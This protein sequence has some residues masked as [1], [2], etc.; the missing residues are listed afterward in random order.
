MGL[1]E[2]DTILHP[3]IDE[4]VLFY[5]NNLNE[6]HELYTRYFDALLIKRCLH[7]SFFRDLKAFREQP[8]VISLLDKAAQDRKIYRETTI[9]YLN[10][11]FAHPWCKKTPLKKG[12]WRAE[13]G[14]IQ[15][16]QRNTE[17]VKEEESLH[18]L[19]V[20]IWII[21]RARMFPG[22]DRVRQWCFD[23]RQRLKE[24][25]QNRL[26]MAALEQHNRAFEA[27]TLHIE[28]EIAKAVSDSRLDDIDE[29][30]AAHAATSVLRLAAAGIILSQE[31]K[32][33]LRWL[34]K[35]PS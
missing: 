1:I 13:W 27:G 20:P 31:P 29:R 10:S 24:Q 32:R 3:D 23:E 33:K 2:D 19:L 8:S 21:M 17:I 35:K 16:K 6:G 11:R 14:N 26:T 4:D 15:G 22:E 5:I 30:P 12:F 34:I 9:A 28:H 7:R 25:S 18:K